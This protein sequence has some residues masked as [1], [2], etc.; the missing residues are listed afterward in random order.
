MSSEIRSSASLGGQMRRPNDLQ[1][2]GEEKVLPSL[3]MIIPQG[4]VLKNK[5]EAAEK[6]L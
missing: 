1:A 2:V 3:L 6:K 4:R 5:P